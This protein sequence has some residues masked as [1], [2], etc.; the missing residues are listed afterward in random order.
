[1]YAYIIKNGTTACFFNAASSCKFT[2]TA[3]TGEA[4]RKKGVWCGVYRRRAAG[5]ETGDTPSGFS[6]VALV[7][8]CVP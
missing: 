7:L 2:G 3:T 5:E 6:M 4:A 8:G 1:M